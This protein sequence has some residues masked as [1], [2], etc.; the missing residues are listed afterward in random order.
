[1]LFVGVVAQK[2]Q[3]RKFEAIQFLTIVNS[4]K[5][6]THI[7]AQPFIPHNIDLRLLIFL[8][9]LG[10][11]LCRILAC[12]LALV[13]RQKVIVIFRHIVII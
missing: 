6:F 8:N 13:F 4:R 3:W 12:I 1:M 5:F 10:L 2:F 9:S 11:I 7:H